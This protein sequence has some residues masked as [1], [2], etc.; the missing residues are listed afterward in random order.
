MK[1]VQSDGDWVLI[2]FWDRLV[3]C[4]LLV[5]MKFPVKIFMAGLSHCQRNVADNKV[6]VHDGGQ[7]VTCF[8]ICAARRSR[9]CEHWRR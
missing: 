8:A 7:S 1:K 6:V 4:L 9:A 2:H 3:T 5:G